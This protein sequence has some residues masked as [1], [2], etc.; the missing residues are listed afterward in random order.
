MN[1]DILAAQ[2]AALSAENSHLRADLKRLWHFACRQASAFVSYEMIAAGVS[3]L[4]RHLADDAF[5]VLPDEEIVELIFLAMRAVE[6]GR[7]QL[8]HS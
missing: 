8:D 3:E 6:R 5:R 7:Q 4:Q 2:V 1:P